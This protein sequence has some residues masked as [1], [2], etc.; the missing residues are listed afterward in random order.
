MQVR[1]MLTFEEAFLGVEKKVS[2]S[3][4]VIDEDVELRTC[5]TCGGRGAVAQQVQ[6]P[7]GVMQ[8]QVTCPDCGGLGKQAYRDGKKVA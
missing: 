7:F 1:I 6:T 3:R 2:Y 8:S 4:N 5:A